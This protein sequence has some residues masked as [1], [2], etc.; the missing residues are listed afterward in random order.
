MLPESRFRTAL[1]REGGKL[2]DRHGRPSA[3]E[4][5]AWLAQELSFLYAVERKILRRAALARQS[6]WLC[7]AVL[8]AGVCFA[9]WAVVGAFGRS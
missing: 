9:V 6:R 3:S 8:A 2:M 7:A 4:V 1:E 5:E